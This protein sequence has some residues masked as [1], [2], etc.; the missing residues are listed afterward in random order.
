[1][2]KRVAVNPQAFKA[3]TE[4]PPPF[5]IEYQG[6]LLRVLLED[7]GFARPV[8]EFIKPTFFQNEVHSW[9]W[10]TALFISLSKA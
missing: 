8:M 3:P 10:A 4:E 1:M 7:S 2:V 6:M 9:A 5:G